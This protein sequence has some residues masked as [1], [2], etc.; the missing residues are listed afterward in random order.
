MGWYEDYENDHDDLLEKIGLSA[1]IE[2]AKKELAEVEEKLQAARNSASSF[3][4][5]D[6]AEKKAE[7]DEIEKTVASLEARKKEL[8]EMLAKKEEQLSDLENN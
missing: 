3:N 4:I 7:Y 5:L 1:A 2:K 6:Y 8:K